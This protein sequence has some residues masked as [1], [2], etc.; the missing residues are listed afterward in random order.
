KRPDRKYIS[1]SV[2]KRSEIRGWSVFYREGDKLVWGDALFQRGDTDSVV[3]I[4]RYISSHPHTKGVR[5]IEGWFSERPQWWNG[6]LTKIGFRI[7]KEPNNL[8]LTLP[9]VNDTTLS[10]TIKHFYYTKG[11]SDLF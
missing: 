2:L 4:L 6:I 5:C 8:H 3:E 1:L 7:E 11:D 10:N 9:I